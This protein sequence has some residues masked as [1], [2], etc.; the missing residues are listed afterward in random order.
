MKHRKRRKPAYIPVG[1]AAAMVLLLGTLLP[2]L[3]AEENS[4]DWYYE[5]V[6]RALSEEN[7]TH[8]LDLLTAAKERYPDTTL[9]NIMLADL[10]YNKELYANALE[11]YL[12]AETKQPRDTYVL[13]M[14]AMCY[15]LLNQEDRA[16]DYYRKILDI[17]PQ[18]LDATDWMGWVYQKTYQLKKAEELLLE[19]IDRFGMRAQLAG[20]LGS[21]YADLYEYDKS[22]FYYNKAI[23]LSLQ[24]NNRGRAAIYYY[25]LSILEKN[26]YKFDRAFAACQN[27][28]DLGEW[29]SGKR[30]KGTLLQMRME[31][32]AARRE[33]ENADLYDDSAYSKIDLADLDL[34]FGNLR[35]ARERVYAILDSKDL[36]WLLYYSTNTNEYYE[37]LYGLLAEIYRGLAEEEWRM[38]REGLLEELGGFVQWAVYSLQSWYYDQKYR[39]AGIKTAHAYLEEDNL[40]RAYQELTDLNKDYPD[41]ALGYCLAAERIETRMIPGSAPGYLLERGGF[42]RS[43]PLLEEALEGFDSYWQKQEISRALRKLVP[44]LRQ[45]G[46]TSRARTAL[47][48]LYRLNPGGLFRY[49]MGLPLELSLEIDDEKARAEAR[50]CFTE[51]LR[52]A[53]SDISAPGDT[54]GFE[55]R[56]RLHWQAGGGLNFE[57]TE[58]TTGRPVRRGVIPAGTG[59]VR[60]RCARF[61]RQVLFDSV[62]AVR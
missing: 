20:T 37:R 28:I 23:E 21:V 33:Y 43:V 3:P 17:D 32:A 26:F 55:Y 7:Y 48:R 4:E 6:N 14:T 36:S 10:Y 29:S 47:S 56:L 11:E 45:R 50:A 24:E 44:L 9:F 41:V 59:S 49:G 5:Q 34:E 12:R 53:G 13:S 60:A 62:Y 16:L 57:L 30:M 31:Y 39:L 51:M 54:Q 38:P 25:N 1:A 46:E 40:L 8:A 27:A 18:N 15:G 19:A 22:S 2:V 58:I 52:K 42:S 61:M 35:A